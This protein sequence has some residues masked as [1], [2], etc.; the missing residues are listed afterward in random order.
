MCVAFVIGCVTPMLLAQSA[1]SSTP[2]GQP[3]ARRLARLRWLARELDLTGAE[4]A[5]IKTILKKT[6]QSVV[7]IRNDSSLSPADRKE[8]IQAARKDAR[9]EIR[10]VLTPEQRAKLKALRQ[11]IGLTDAQRAQI[12]TI[13]QQA[14]R[15]VRSIRHDAALSPA[16]R[17]E[18]VQAARKDARHQMLAVL[19]PEQRAK[20]K[21]RRQQHS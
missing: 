18:K 13:F 9:Q 10:T 14:R 16:A 21:A 2:A 4:R 3:G 12:K 6:H 5:R 7:A 8:K 17:R 20:L 1:S 19:T 15:D 11:E